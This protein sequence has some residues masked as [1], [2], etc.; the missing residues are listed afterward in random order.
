MCN[1]LVLVASGTYIE[2]CQ[3]CLRGS[4]VLGHELEA[5]VEEL[6]SWKTGCEAFGT[7]DANG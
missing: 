5:H 3:G 6:P 4:I 7:S 1:G 2:T